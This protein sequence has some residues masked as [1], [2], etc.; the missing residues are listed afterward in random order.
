MTFGSY[1]L[2]KIMAKLVGVL[3]YHIAVHDIDVWRA[4]YYTGIL[5]VYIH[6]LLQP[7]SQYPLIFSMYAKKER[8]L[9]TRNHMTNLIPID[10]HIPMVVTVLSFVLHSSTLDVGHVILLIRLSLF[11]CIH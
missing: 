11:S 7:C 10:C 8:E 5:Y 3:I 4:S 9:G 2:F 1:G 6:V